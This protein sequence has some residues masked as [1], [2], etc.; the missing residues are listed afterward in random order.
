M[1]SAQRLGFQ[2]VAKYLRPALYGLIFS[3]MSIVGAASGESATKKTPTTDP[4]SVVRQLYAAYRANDT[5][6]GRS[7]IAPN[8]TWEWFGPKYIIPFA[9]TWNGPDGVDD[10]F[11]TL[12]AALKDGDF[13]QREYIVDGEVV[14]VPGFDEGTVRAT[15]GHFRVNN[16]HFFRVH[17]GQIVQF[18]EYIDTGPIVEAFTP[19]DSARGRALFE[20][21]RIAVGSESRG[22]ASVPG[23]SGSDAND[24]VRQLRDYRSGLQQRQGPMRDCA[25]SLPGD[26][27]T[28]DLAA[29]VASLPIYPNP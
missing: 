25:L 22:R 20:K 1:D 16:L 19:A 14:A 10:F 11:K 8:A 2:V 24:L 21:C 15:G 12:K 27:G 26:R 7:L 18:E 3:G 9:G 23:L 6:K 28:R 17:N 13:G 5:A 4:E 29:Y